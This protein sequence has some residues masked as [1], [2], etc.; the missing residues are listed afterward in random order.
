LRGRA[1][2][3]ELASVR[4]AVGELCARFAPYPGLVQP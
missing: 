4:T 2:P 1:N 3:G